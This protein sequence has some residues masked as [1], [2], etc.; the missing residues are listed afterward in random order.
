MHVERVLICGSRD[1]SD[2]DLVSALLDHI[3]DHV[4]DTECFPTI[5][6]GG[7]RGVDRLAD[8][9]AEDSRMGRDI[10]RADWEGQGKAAG[11]IRN[12]QMLDSGVD[13]CIAI[14]NKP[15]AESRGTADMVRRCR[16]AGVPVSLV[17][18]PC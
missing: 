11:F 2:S 4:V 3:F 13:L 7:A 14:T 12:Q 6:T 9:W 5:V 15:L 1:L 16:A 8:L 18:L 10:F 17:E